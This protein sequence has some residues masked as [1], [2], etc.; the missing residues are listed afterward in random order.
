MRAF[1]Y[2]SAML[3]VLA[4]L[5]V[6]VFFLPDLIGPLPAVLCGAA[7]IGCAFFTY[8]RWCQDDGESEESRPQE[9]TGEDPR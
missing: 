7:V 5:L 8:N 1:F 4:A 9:D 6:L 2:S 3:Y